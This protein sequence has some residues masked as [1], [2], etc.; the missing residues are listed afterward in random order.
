MNLMNTNILLNSEVRIY[1]GLV[2]RLSLDPP[3]KEDYTQSKAQAC[4]LDTQVFPLTDYGS[5]EET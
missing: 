5:L 3:D 4:L 1:P 2:C